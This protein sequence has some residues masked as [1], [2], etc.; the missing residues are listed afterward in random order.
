MTG[1]LL[2]RVNEKVNTLSS[3]QSLDVFAYARQGCGRQSLM[4]VLDDTVLS[5]N[6]PEI[7]SIPSDSAIVILC[8]LNLSRDH[9]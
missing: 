5:I 1:H 6:A 4:G 7:E 9:Y 3:T 8:Q 2:V